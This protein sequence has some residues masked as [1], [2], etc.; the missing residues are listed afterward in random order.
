MLSEAERAVL[1]RLGIFMG[2]FTLDA[3]CAV[4]VDPSLLKSDV[5]DAVAEI[6]EKSLAVAGVEQDMSEAG[7]VPHAAQLLRR[8]DGTRVD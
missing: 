5:I 4:A 2:G 7:L 6:V 1:R 8:G 3:A